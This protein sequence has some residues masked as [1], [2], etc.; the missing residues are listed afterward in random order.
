M[1]D[2]T[3]LALAAAR[4]LAHTR[5]RSSAV[6]ERAREAAILAME[7]AFD[8][9]RRRRRDPPISTDRSDRRGRRP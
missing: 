3:L 9:A 4:R 6:H 7:K 1:N 5:V 2:D 8:R